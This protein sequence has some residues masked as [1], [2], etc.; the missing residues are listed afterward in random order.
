MFIRAFDMD[1]RVSGNADAEL[2]ILFNQS[3]GITPEVE[4][5]LYVYK[6]PKN[7]ILKV[8]TS[9]VSGRVNLAYFYIDKNGERQSIKY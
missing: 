1:F 2:I 7:S 8:K 4:N 5:G 6:I 9:G 3:D